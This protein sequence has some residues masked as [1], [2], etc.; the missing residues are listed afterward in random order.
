M[1]SRCIKRTIRPFS[2]FLGYTEQVDKGK[3]IFQQNIS[4]NRK[5][6][7]REVNVTA[8]FIVRRNNFSRYKAILN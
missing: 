1:L 7:V 6:S 4:F 5:I 8:N 2:E 3:T